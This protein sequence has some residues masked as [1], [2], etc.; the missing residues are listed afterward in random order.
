MAGVVLVALHRP[1]DAP[2]LLTAA[3]T[4]AQLAGAGRVIGLCARLPPRETILPTEEI[5]TAQQEARLRAEERQ[6]GEAVKARFETWRSATPVAAEWV[7]VES[8]ADRAVGE[9]G[10][11]ADYIVLGRPGERMGETARQALHAALFD[12]AR[13]VLLVPAETPPAPFGRR[14]AIAWRDD[15]G[16][17]RAVLAALRC[18]G[19]AE[20]IHVLAGRKDDAA[21]PRLPDVLDEHGIAAEL[22]V[23][24]ITGQTRFGEALAAKAR[25]LGCDMLVMGAFVHHPTLTLVFGGVTRHMLAHAEIPVLMRH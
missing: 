10:R 25:E 5:L 9:W 7:D 8:R 1:D 11:R 13:P 24:P 12:T 6:R 22:H 19:R 18:L 3:A 15:P 17:L 20:Q 16:T 21:M 23:L 4:L 2:R 14:V